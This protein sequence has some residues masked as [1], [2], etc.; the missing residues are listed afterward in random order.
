MM[1]KITGFLKL[2]K[3][4]SSGIE[5]KLELKDWGVLFKC[6]LFSERRR[7]HLFS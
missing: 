5:R 7:Q 4:R 2:M 3:L 1:I 6:N